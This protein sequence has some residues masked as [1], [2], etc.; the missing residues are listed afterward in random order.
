MPTKSRNTEK[1]T[2]SEVGTVAKAPQ[3]ETLER[4]G[5]K[6]IVPRHEIVETA[7]AYTLRLETPG[8]RKE[9][10][11]IRADRDTLVIE[12]KREE[13][14]EGLT[15]LVQERPT[16]VYQRVFQMDN[17][18]DGKKISACV[19][20]GVVTITIPKASHTQPRRIQVS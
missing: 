15:P 17:T 3:V 5:E 6:P 14:S 8:V 13:T 12:G 16:G 4:R 1:G 18:V 2:G 11:E 10:L 20:N 7:T 9:T 19:E